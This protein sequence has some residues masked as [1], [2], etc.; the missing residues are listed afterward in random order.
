MPNSYTET[1]SDEQRDG[2][3]TVPRGH[4][5]ESIHAHIQSYLILQMPNQLSRLCVKFVQRW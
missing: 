4:C 2:K 5:F 1:Q 3:M